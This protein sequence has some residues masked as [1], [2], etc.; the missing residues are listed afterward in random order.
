MYKLTEIRKEINAHKLK[1]WCRSAR[2]K[3]EWSKHDSSG[4]MSNTKQ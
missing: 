2:Y 1:S 3:Y 4:I